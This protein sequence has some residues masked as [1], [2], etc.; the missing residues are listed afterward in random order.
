M[1][2]SVNGLQDVL[3]NLN[4]E[5]QGI[6]NRTL[7]G[8]GKVGLFIKG[9]SVEMVPQDKGILINSAYHQT[10]NT[11]NGPV[12]RIGYTAKYAPYVH[13]MPETYNYSKAGTGPKFLEKPVKDNYNFILE[14]IRRNAHV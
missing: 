8:L 10:A 2:S 11:S 5:I 4:R 9:E 3:R 12:V 7:T 14:L 13:E 6:E 1:T